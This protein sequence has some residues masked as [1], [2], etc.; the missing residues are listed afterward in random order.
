VA[1]G[2][3]SDYYGGALDRCSV[4]FTDIYE[5]YFGFPGVIRVG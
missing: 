2:G 3:G 5:A 4:S 1:G